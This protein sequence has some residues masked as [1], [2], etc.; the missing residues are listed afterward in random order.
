MNPSSEHRIESFGMKELSRL[1]RLIYAM[2][3][4]SIKKYCECEWKIV[5]DVWCGYNA[6]FL[7]KIGKL[8]H[9]SKMIAFD[10][11]L[12]QEFL[13]KEGVKSIE[14][15]LNKDFPLDEKVDLIFATAILEHLDKPVWFLTNCHKYLNPGGILL[16]T[17]PSIRSQ[18]I[19]EFLA[20]KVRIISEEEIRDHKE[21]FDRKRLREYCTKAWFNLEKI[22][23]EYFEFGMNNLIVATKS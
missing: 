22:H 17:T 16:L 18:P 11:K 15:D 5:M 9:P 2:R 21:Y 19:L 4:A 23:H 13:L 7:R 10:L 6:D 12:N 1:D 3:V 20:Y 8:Y 14:W